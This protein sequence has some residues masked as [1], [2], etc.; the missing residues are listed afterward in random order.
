M[1]FRQRPL[2]LPSHTAT[3]VQGPA[4][5]LSLSDTCLPL[6]LC[7]VVHSLRGYPQQCSPQQNSCDGLIDLTILFC[8]VCVCAEL[9]KWLPGRSA[10]GLRQA[11]AHNV[12]GCEASVLAKLTANNWPSDLCSLL[13]AWPGPSTKAKVCR[14]GVMAAAVMEYGWF[15][16]VASVR[17]GLARLRLLCQDS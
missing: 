12:E 6:A 8:C 2:A 3:D 15:T 10:A 14:A 4:A 11:Y 5:M 17:V 1:K 7:A 9:A 16:P 13:A